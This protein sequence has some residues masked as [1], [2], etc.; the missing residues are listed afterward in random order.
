MAQCLH[1]SPDSSGDIV[2]VMSLVY[3]TS[4]SVESCSDLYHLCVVRQALSSGIV[5]KNLRA[6]AGSLW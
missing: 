5:C 1:E 6:I 4:S 3:E 2:L